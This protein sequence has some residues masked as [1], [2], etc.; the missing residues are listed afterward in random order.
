[1][2]NKKE[3]ELIISSLENSITS[4]MRKGSLFIIVYS[5]IW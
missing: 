1:M 3:K 2:K 4:F 5:Y